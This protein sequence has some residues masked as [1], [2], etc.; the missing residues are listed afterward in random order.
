MKHTVFPADFLFGGATAANQMEGAYNEGG[1]GLSIQD[2]MPHGIMGP[3]TPVPTED[4]LKLE[5]ID[6]YH[7]YREDI[8]LFAEMGFRVFRMSIAWTRIFPNGDEEEPNEEGLAFYDRVFDEL[9]AHG[10]EPLVTLSHYE[11]PLGLARKYNGWVGR[12]MIG[13]FEKFARTVFTRYREKVRYWLTFNEINA[14]L[15]QPYLAGGICTP[16]DQLSKSDLYRAVHHELIA[17]A[18]AVRLCHEIIPDAKIGNMIIAAP[19]YPLTPAPEDVLAAMELERETY[20]FSDVQVFGAYPAYT[21]RLFRENGI[22][23]DV[24]P[25]DAEILRNTVDFVSFSY[26]MSMCASAT[27]HTAGMGNIMGGVPNPTLRASEWGWQI[28]PDGLRIILNRLHD[29]YRIPLF[30]AEN[31][32]GAHDTLVRGA[33]GT[34]TVEDDYRIA[35]LTNH[36]RAVGEAIR[37]GIPV[38]GYTMWGCIDLVSA[39]TA[40][41]SKR[42]GFIYVDRNDD[43]SGTMAR[44]RKKSFDW[45]R[46]VIRTN[47]ECLF[48]QEKPTAAK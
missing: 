33:N 46:Q 3:T 37:D 36:L 42:Y 34:P 26:Y 24:L 14:I 43:G 11:T 41:M 1:K 39:S 18:L 17:S 45:Y 38:M 28:D 7:R 13:F 47:G 8:A 25:E 30:V 31:G 5:G 40:Q 22:E 19:V 35:Y 15:R 9:R 4:N 20:L 6:F 23:I 10:I 32:L 48:P 12:E 21:T 2:V 44:Y 16:A 27:D 29:R